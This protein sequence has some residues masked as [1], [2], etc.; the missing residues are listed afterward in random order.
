MGKHATLIQE[1]L[2]VVS[3]KMAQGQRWARLHARDFDLTHPIVR[4]IT[5]AA[6]YA[7]THEKR[8]G[9]SIG[10]DYVLGK[11]WKRIVIAIR[12]LLN[13]ELNGLDG[14]TLDSLLCKML[15]AEGF[16]T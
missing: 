7:D 3:E 8:F 15:E 4:L 1:S 14:G 12:G 13:G 9:S 2:S 10:H 6:D 5:A 11:D 16:E